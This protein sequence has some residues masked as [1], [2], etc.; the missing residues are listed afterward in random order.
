MS[1]RFCRFVSFLGALTSSVLADLRC[2]GGPASGRRCQGNVSRAGDH[3][4]LL[5]GRNH[6]LYAAHKPAQ[7]GVAVVMPPEHPRHT[8]Q[9]LVPLALTGN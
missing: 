5:G 4:F 7:A 1:P 6:L 8:L 9:P 2:H 3:G